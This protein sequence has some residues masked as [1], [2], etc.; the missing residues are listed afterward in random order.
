[1]VKFLMD[2]QLFIATPNFLLLLKRP[3][4]KRNCGQI[5]GRQD[6][7]MIATPKK[8]ETK[9]QKRATLVSINVRNI[10]LTNFMSCFVLRK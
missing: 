4:T 9:V 10:I 2:W 3:I 6:M 5:L 7:M 8:Y 1:M